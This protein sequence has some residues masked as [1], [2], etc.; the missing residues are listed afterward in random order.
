MGNSDILRSE[1]DLRL[2][3]K[4]CLTNKDCDFY[5]VRLQLCNT[6]SEKEFREYVEK[7]KQ[8]FIEQGKKSVIEY[9]DKKDRYSKKIKLRTDKMVYGLSSH[10]VT[11]TF[12]V[13][14]ASS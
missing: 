3:E 13:L 12:S 11:I 9:R 14:S 4:I 2:E 5:E 8:R 10:M 7:H 6:F 1:Y